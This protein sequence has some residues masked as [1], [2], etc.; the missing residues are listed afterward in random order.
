[1]Q[2]IQ[3]CTISARARGGKLRTRSKAYTVLTLIQVIARDGAGTA[4]PSVDKDCDLES[5]ESSPSCNVEPEG[6]ITFENPGAIQADAESVEGL[7]H[8]EQ[9]DHLPAQGGSLSPNIGVPSIAPYPS[10]DPEVPSIPTPAA[11]DVE[12]KHTSCKV[13]LE[14]TGEESGRDGLNIASLKVEINEAALAP[15]ADYSTSS[16]SS[17]NT[18]APSGM[19][20]KV[21]HS[22]DC[23]TN[24]STNSMF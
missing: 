23:Y 16:R 18:G 11:L 19:D 24:D 4:T 14:P 8:Q 7:P 3:F 20:S 17:S 10:A 1:M 9:V 5:T 21:R 13:T 22:F 2:Y 12:E 15:D 6:A